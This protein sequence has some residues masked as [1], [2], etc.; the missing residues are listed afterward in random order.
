MD[1]QS[2]A[3]NWSIWN[4]LR[5]FGFLSHMILYFVVTMLTGAVVLLSQ[6]QKSSGKFE[7]RSKPY[8]SVLRELQRSEGTPLGFSERFRQLFLYFELSK[9][10]LKPQENELTQAVKANTNGKLNIYQKKQAALLDWAAA[11]YDI[12]DDSLLTGE[13]RNFLNDLLTDDVVSEAEGWFYIIDAPTY[14]KTEQK[15]NESFVETHRGKFDPRYIIPEKRSGAIVDSNF[16]LEDAKHLFKTIANLPKDIIKKL[17]EK[18]HKNISLNSEEGC[19]FRVE[20]NRI[21]LLDNQ[22]RKSDG[23]LSLEGTEIKENLPDGLVVFDG[24]LGS[25]GGRADDLFFVDRKLVYIDNVKPE[26]VNSELVDIPGV[27]AYYNNK[28]LANELCRKLNNQSSFPEDVPALLS[29]FKRFPFRVFTRHPEK[30][31]I[32]N[33]ADLNGVL[34]VERFTKQRQK[35]NIK[36]LTLDK[37]LRYWQS[38]RAH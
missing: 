3:K 7:E 37:L 28:V 6:N 9:V 17:S 2:Q 11:S 1:N 18:F 24:S 29:G 32:V 15:I 30:F 16:L 23:Y 12:L 31:Q 25:Y 13:I 20:N 35:P 27:V 22:G 33:R 10:G 4:T 38:H 8:Y 36:L 21:F 26:K 34:Q 5:G 14:K 19:I